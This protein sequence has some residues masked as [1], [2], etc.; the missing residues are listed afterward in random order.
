MID[1]SKLDKKM[2]A[3]TLDFSILPKNTQ[4]AE[5]LKGCELT[6]KY[7]FAA[8]YSSSAYWSPL[9]AA[10]LAGTDAEVGTGIA[11]PFGSAPRRSRPSRSR[12]RCGAAAPP[13]TW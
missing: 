6:R 13:W 11:F 10:E 5:I 7:G 4:K 2:L 12:T 9:V 8:F 1:M 3:K